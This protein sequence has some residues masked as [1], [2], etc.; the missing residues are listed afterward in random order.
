MLTYAIGDIHGCADQ[1]DRLL[2]KIEEHRAGRARKLVF[3][4]D[5]IDRGRDSAKVVAALEQLQIADPEGVIC[6]RGNHEQ[7]MLDAI[8]TGDDQLY[9]H[10]LVNGG[11]AALASFE[12]AMPDGMNRKTL[13]W[14]SQLPLTTE[15]TQRYFVHA[16]FDPRRP[17]P[18]EDTKTCLWIREPFLDAVHDF[19][20][21]V[22]H[23]HTPLVSGEPDVR[24]FRTNLDTGCVF[25][26][27]LTAGVFTDDQ[28]RAVEFLQVQ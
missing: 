9:E 15:D 2:G 10:W 1:L 5:Y 20:K 21:H 22:V 6:L 16:G 28:A 12:A 19:G 27:W 26:G 18:Q 24:S 3:L 14:I 17:A 7:M 4:G 13:T 23:G 8:R 11:E 25:G